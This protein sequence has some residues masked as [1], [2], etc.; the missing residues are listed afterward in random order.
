ME[1]SHSVAVSGNRAGAVGVGVVEHAH[2]SGQ[3]QL[4]L[5]F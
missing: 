4:G 2:R 1:F 5:G 3:H